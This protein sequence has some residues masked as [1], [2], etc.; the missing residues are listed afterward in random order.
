MP[1]GR[2][3][4]GIRL[5][6]QVFPAPVTGR[7]CARI[8]L[9]RTSCGMDVGWNRRPLV[10]AASFFR[11][12]VHLRPARSILLLRCGV[13]SVAKLALG[14]E[15]YYEQQVALG[16]DDYY[17]GRGESPGL[18]VGLGCGGLELVGAVEDGDLGTLLSRAEPRRR[19][20]PARA[21]PRAHDH[22]PYPRRGDRRAGATS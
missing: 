9:L 14:Q 18:W 21:G 16:L 6:E 17:A 19:R 20:A 15:A 3:R 13:L 8:A 1:V 4:S 11:T 7:F 10:A 2:I 12:W 22:R 5:F